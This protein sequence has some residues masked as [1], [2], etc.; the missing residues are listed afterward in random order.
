MFE[1]RVVIA[2]TDIVTDI[3]ARVSGGLLAIRLVQ[4]DSVRCA[5]RGRARLRGG[6][7]RVLVG[8]CCNQL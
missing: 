3:T 6:R 5:Q 8:A 1:G 2:V 4:T 7:A